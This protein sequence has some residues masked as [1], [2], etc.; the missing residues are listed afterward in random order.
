MSSYSSFKQTEWP[1]GTAPN[2]FP[3][4]KRTHFKLRLELA[5]N[6]QSPFSCIIG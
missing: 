6:E 3:L 4:C 2:K 5:I 1:I